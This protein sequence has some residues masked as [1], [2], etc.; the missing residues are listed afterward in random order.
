MK[1]AIA[2][3]VLCAVLLSCTAAADSWPEWA[4][5]VKDWAINEGIS[6]E[7]C[8]RDRPALCRRGA[9]CRRITF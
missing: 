2:I 7:M 3:I 5:P 6:E 4:E 9:A 8:I 1:K